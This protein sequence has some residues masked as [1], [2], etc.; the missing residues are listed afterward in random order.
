V[1]STQV[2]LPGIDGALAD[3]K[4]FGEQRT[5]TMRLAYLNGGK[6]IPLL[7]HMAPEPLG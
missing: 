4:R 6:P 5:R 7:A 3:P 2:E 1:H